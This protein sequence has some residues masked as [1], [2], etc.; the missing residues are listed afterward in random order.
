MQFAY[1]TAALIFIAVWI[2]LFVL[3]KDLRREMIVMSLIATPLGLFDIIAVPLYWQPQTL[4]NI[5]VGIEGLV[6]SFALGGITSVL[7]AEIAHKRF[8]HIHKYH[9]GAALIVLAATAAIFLPLALEKVI[10][11]AIII[12]II[13]LTG[14]GVMLYLRKDLVKSSLIGAFSFG[15]LYFILIKTWLTIY[16]AAAEWFIFKGLPQVHLLGV[17][18]W[19][20]LFGIIFAAYWG[21]VYQLIFGYRLVKKSKKK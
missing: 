14:L 5:P 20:L 8:Q 13:L 3:R 10:H 19:E 1:L 7:Y 2:V 15:I 16:P 6:Y 17:P 11:P 4:F 9:K 18:L 12:Y 21:N